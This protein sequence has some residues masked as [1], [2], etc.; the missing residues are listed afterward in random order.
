VSVSSSSLSLYNKQKDIRRKTCSIPDKLKNV[1]AITLTVL[2][3]LTGSGVS[4]VISNTGPSSILLPAEG[5]PSIDFTH[6]V[7]SGDVTSDSAVLWTRIDQEAI[8]KLEV[9]T[10]PGFKKLDFKENVRADEDDD[11]TLKATAEDLQPNQIYYYK[12]RHGSSS[13]ETGIFKTAPIS[14]DVEGQ[15]QPPDIDFAWTGDS[16]PSKIDDIPSLW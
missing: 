3:I 9:S 2:I 6:G 16:D 4:F 13:S 1:K 15:P 5:V 10:D 11:F 14:T 7:A 12:W 8:V